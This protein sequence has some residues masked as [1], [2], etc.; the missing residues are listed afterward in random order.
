[1]GAGQDELER[2]VARKSRLVAV[3]IAATMVLWLGANFIG[4]KI[5][6]AGRYAFLFDLL[7]LAGFTWSLIVIYQIWRARQQ[8]RD[9]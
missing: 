8:M 6:L 4:A 7:A 2:Q 3:V 1:M 5:G 9:G